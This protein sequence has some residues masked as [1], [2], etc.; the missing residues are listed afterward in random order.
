MHIFFEIDFKISYAREKN[1]FVCTAP[2]LKSC[3]CVPLRSQIGRLLTLIYMFILC[4][5]SAHSSTQSTKKSPILFLHVPRYLPPVSAAICALRPSSLYF[6][7]IL[8]LLYPHSTAPTVHRAHLPTVPTA[9]AVTSAPIH[10]IHRTIHPPHPS[11]VPTVPRHRTPVRPPPYPRTTYPPLDKFKYPIFK[12]L[13]I[14][15]H[16]EPPT[17]YISTGFLGSSVRQPQVSLRTALPAEGKGAALKLVFSCMVKVAGLSQKLE[18]HS[19]LVYHIEKSGGFGI[20]SPW[21][22]NVQDE[23]VLGNCFLDPGTKTEGNGV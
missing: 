17:T 14:I 16:H 18:P 9:P 2:F 19:I 3:S 21:F 12:N 10:R 6:S 20:D 13:Q 15:S 7:T 5:V 4:S 23:P 22:K 1:N 11:T 8:I